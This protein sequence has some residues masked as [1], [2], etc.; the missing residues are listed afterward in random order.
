MHT[1]SSR[2]ARLA[3][4]IA[5]AVAAPGVLFA[6]QPAT[7]SP[8]EALTAEGYVKPPALIEKLVTAPRQNNVAL[9]NL[10]PDRKFF[11]VSVTDGLPS[12]QTF[13]KPHYYFAGLQVDYKANRARALT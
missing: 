9:T 10:G 13:G 6:Q 5:Y 4:A 1:M 8:R 11:L 3:V 7:W 12:T 2:R